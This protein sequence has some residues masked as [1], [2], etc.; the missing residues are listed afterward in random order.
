MPNLRNRHLVPGTI[1][2]AAMIPNT[3]TNALVD[4][5]FTA[6]SITGLKL[7]ASTVPQT[8]WDT[9]A[10]ARSADFF[11]DQSAPSTTVGRGVV[12]GAGNECQANTTT[13]PSLNV[14]IALGGIVY[15]NQG[16]ESNLSAAP[17]T[18]GPFPVPLGGGDSAINVVVV[19][20]S[21]ALVIRLGTPAAGPVAPALTIG[22]VPL[23]SVTIPNGTVSI[24]SSMITDLRSRAAVEASKIGVTAGAFLVGNIKGLGSSVLKNFSI[25]L[26]LFGAW[27]VD[28]DGANTN[29]GGLVGTEPNLVAADFAFV[30][31]HG[32]VAFADLSNAS[33]LAGW[34][35]NWQLFSDAGVEEIND[36]FY[37]GFTVPVCEIAFDLSALATWIADGM[38]YEYWNGAAW[39]ALTL[40]GPVGEGYDNTDNVGPTPYNGLRSLQRNGAIVFEPPAD[41]AANVVNAQSAFYVRGR[42]TAAQLSQ[43]PV[44]N[45][46]NPVKVVGAEPLILPN[47]MIVNNIVFN[48]ATAV[49]H[50]A[51]V[52]VMIYDRATGEHRKLT[53]NASTRKDRDNMTAW[54]LKR[55]VSRLSFYVLQEAGGNEPSNVGIEL[56]GQYS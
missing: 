12:V 47:D 50:A 51:P 13:A 16:F 11:M 27:A 1:A 26:N 3:F 49:V 8:S 36:A 32:T 14:L 52:V 6:E 34:A 18:V 41:W 43:T 48:T 15:N 20:A 30:Y 39:V 10:L 23:A 22:D 44:A 24:I 56:E 21:G 53:W 29:G 25:P 40:A 37:L 28:G 45:G 31:D 4:S 33:S 17:Y 38:V 35:A 5:L 42:I 9:G 54:S 7:E 55:T 19:D 46:A 2:A